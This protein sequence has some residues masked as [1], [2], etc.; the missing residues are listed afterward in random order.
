MK[1]RLLLPA[2]IGLSTAHNLAQTVTDFDGN[3]YERVEIGN[4]IWLASNL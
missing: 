4:Q 2:G 3:E 1:T